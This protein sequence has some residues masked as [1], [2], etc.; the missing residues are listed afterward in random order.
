MLTLAGAAS[1]DFASAIKG[2]WS[3]SGFAHGAENA[4][5]AVAAADQGMQIA[6][7]GAGC[8]TEVKFTEIYGEG[9]SGKETVQQGSCTSGFNILVS[10]ARGGDGI[11]IRWFD[12]ENSP[13]GSI[14]VKR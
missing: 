5:A 10:Q 14:V 13:T 8:V 7:D 3:G 6:L 11:E 9:L 2:D 1:A 4:N 12:A